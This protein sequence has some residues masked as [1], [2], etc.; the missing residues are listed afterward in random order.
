M[1]EIDVFG[2]SRILMCFRFG[3]WSVIAKLP[4][5]FIQCFFFPR[6]KIARLGGDNI[7]GGQSKPRARGK[8]GTG[9]AASDTGSRG[10]G[11]SRDRTPAPRGGPKQQPGGSPAEPNLTSVFC[12]GRFGGESE[13]NQQAGV[14]CPPSEL[15]ERYGGE[16]AFCAGSPTRNETASFA[17]SWSQS[18]MASFAS[19]LCRVL[20]SKKGEPLAR[21]VVA[22]VGGWA[23]YY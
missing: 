10:L 13:D 14:F 23:N 3:L 19:Q 8:A 15:A 12:A 2:R 5:F 1:L 20:R 16:T 7:R 21:C 17:G 6:R 22:W 11:V 9:S 4:F 18:R